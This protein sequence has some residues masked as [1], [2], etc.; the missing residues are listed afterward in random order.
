VS[1]DSPLLVDRDGR[2]LVVITFNRP[3]VLNALD[4]AGMEAFAAA[5]EALA[6]PPEPRLLLLRG[7]G[8]S[9]FC[10]GGDQVVLHSALSRA[11]GERLA[12]VMGDALAAME[13]L[14]CP[15]IAAV[16]GFALGGGSE[17]ALACDARVV[18]ANVRF[19]LV[20]SR[21]G[22]VPGWGGGQRLVR[23]VGPARAMTMMAGG[24]PFGAAELDRLGLCATIAPAG[25]AVTIALTLADQWLS[26]DPAVLAALKALL[27][28][29]RD[30]PYDEALAAERA[31][32]PDLWQGE[33]HVRAVEGFRGRREA[34]S[35]KR[36]AP[37]T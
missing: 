6:G 13:R 27:S 15:S 8:T 28:A 21:L 31:L 24:Q 26:L 10:S 19:G 25:E 16:N 7:A 4:W 34:G 20:H 37:E 22:L 11:D 32:F 33:A 23:L 35:P 18:D 12:R 1:A 3:R 9:A 30:L 29:G 14:P 36:A 2:G 17:I 5:I